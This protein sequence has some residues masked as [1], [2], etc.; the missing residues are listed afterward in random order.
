MKAMNIHRKVEDNNQS[1]TTGVK[2]RSG[3]AGSFFRLILLIVLLSAAAVCFLF[4]DKI[5]NF[6]Q[7]SQI[8][9]SGLQKTLT[10]LFSGLTR[11]QSFNSNK[12]FFGQ[13]QN[14]SQNNSFGNLQNNITSTFASAPWNNQKKLQKYSNKKT[15]NKYSKSQKKE[16]KSA[17]AINYLSR[18]KNL[19]VIATDDG[20]YLVVNG[21][22]RLID[23]TEGRHI[24]IIETIDG[25]TWI[26]SDKGAF[27]LDENYQAMLVSCTENKLINIIKSVNG[28]VWLGTFE[29]AYIAS[30]DG[31]SLQEIK[32]T[33][34]KYIH[35]I[36]ETNDYV[37]LGTDEGLY[38]VKKNALFGKNKAKFIKQSEGLWVYSV[39]EVDGEMWLGTD[40]GA[41]VLQEPKFRKNSLALVEGTEEKKVTEIKASDEGISLTTN[42]GLYEIGQDGYLNE[43]S[44]TLSMRP[45]EETVTQI[46]Q[47]TQT[48]PTATIKAR[49]TRNYAPQNEAPKKILETSLRLH[50]DLD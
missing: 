45:E 42:T 44:T 24:Y 37:W 14:P 33:K 6:R 23:G 22:R 43:D 38:K 46:T 7:P 41:Y 18:D 13:A 39:E 9:L 32:G 40:E 5:K 26:G 34:W 28:Q 35:T 2:R 49:E 50:E 48:I 12:N 10:N 3:G 21:K 30:Y 27:I 47:I 19:K 20:A 8:N 31:S 11:K 29:G 15:S 1:L 36:K 4:P 17:N 16:S 25:Q